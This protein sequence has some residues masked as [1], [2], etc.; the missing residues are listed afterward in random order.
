MQIVALTK[1]AEDA[2][3]N[4]GT[5]RREITTNSEEAQIWF[6]R[7]LIWCYGFNHQAA[8]ECFESAIAHDENCAM[9]H[10][11][12]AFAVGPNYN[13]P[14]ETFDDQ[15]LQMSLKQAHD[16]AVKA[17][18]F[19][20]CVAQWEAD[21]IE[22]IQLRYPGD[23]A[24]QDP[25]EW[26][27]TYADA[28]SV[29]HAAHLDDLDV[30]ALYADSLMNLTPWR[31]WDIRTG[32]P[33]P[34]ARTLEA[35][36]ILERTFSELGGKQHPGLLHLYI[37]LME[38]S[39]AP[40]LALPIADHL[41]GMVPDSGHLEHMATHLDVL[42]GDWRRAISSNS[43]AIVADQ[44]FVAQVGAVNFYTLYR[45]HN[46]HFKIYAAMFAGQLSVALDTVA[47]MDEAIP[48]K[49]LR[50]KSPPMADW[51]EAFLSVRIHAMVRFGLWQE[52]IDMD[53]PKDQELYCFKTAMTHYAK[54][55]A[56]A[57]LSQVNE[58]EKAREAFR[59]AA[60]VVKPSRT[61]FNNTCQSV[62]A[63][64]ASMLD[65]EIEYRKQNYELA[66]GHLRHAV[67][68][69]DSLDY[70]EP[71]SWMQPTRHAYGALLL[72]QNHVETAAEV[73]A[74]D[75]GLDKSLPRPLQ[76]PNNVWALHG[77]HEC[78]K[79]LGRSAEA[80]VIEKHL[81]IATAVADVPVGS[82]CFCRRKIDGF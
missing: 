42:C 32:K 28:M 60:K 14:W 26:N 69:D 59:A 65:G 16:A 68:L 47:Q 39:P 45:C 54:G 44:K 56:Y 37:H 38:M 17:K 53:L 1:A 20:K 29:A 19:A 34:K 48:E 80:A 9:A 64:A 78:L 72:E 50:I 22:A 76:H 55:V 43:D 82:S 31:L 30:N 70:D 49:L 35:R 46:M 23:I 71:W 63:I 21:L 36:Q 3:Y 62:M 2:Y 25:M 79:R 66:F 4:L 8:V 24:D 57:A 73:Y 75:L 67:I 61:L 7:G 13:K 77:Y 11:G 10:W 6:D 27:K 15:D 41:R 51:L 81:K 74:A 5:Y 40:E 33:N 18:K 12:L 52:I 58:A